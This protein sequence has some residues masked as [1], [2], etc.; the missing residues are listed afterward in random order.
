MFGNGNI[1]E[2]SRNIR[3]CLMQISKQD[4]WM[5]LNE[6][7]EDLQRCVW[8]GEMFQILVVILQK[9]GVVLNGPIDLI[10]RP[11]LIGQSILG[12]K[13]F[14]GR[15]TP[16]AIFIESVPI[17]TLL[18]LLEQFLSRFTLYPSTLPIPKNKVVC[19]M[20]GPLEMATF[21]EIFQ[22][23]GRGLVPDLQHIIIVL[24]GQ[25]K[26][27]LDFRA[28][29]LNDAVHLFGGIPNRHITP[30]CSWSAARW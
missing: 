15:A 29:C 30:A 2:I 1:D 20:H 22:W 17:G 9:Q 3:A 26:G 10:R 25:Q 23:N 7:M 11:N 12:S 21:I 14:P 8:N 13:G 24:S 4:A 28:F 19:G 6:L 16:D 27:K 5:L 18:R